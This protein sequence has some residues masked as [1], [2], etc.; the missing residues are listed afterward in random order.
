[1]DD[2][3]TQC[4]TS[5][6]VKCKDHICKDH[7]CKHIIQITEQTEVVCSCKKSEQYQLIVEAE[8]QVNFKS[9]N[10]HIIPNWGKHQTAPIR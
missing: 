8:F 5:Y 6:K 4:S 1:M 3:Y 9:K 10:F 2:S 7:I